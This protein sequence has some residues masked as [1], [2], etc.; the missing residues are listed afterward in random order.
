MAF[1]E[2]APR[3]NSLTVDNHE[4]ARTARL[5]LDVLGCIGKTERGA[6][7]GHAALAYPCNHRCG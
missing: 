2:H 5:G 1:V 6:R 7:E 4:Q 3:V